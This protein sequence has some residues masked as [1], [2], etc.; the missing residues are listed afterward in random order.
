[1]F[2]FPQDLSWTILRN[3]SL[4]GNIHQGSPSERKKE[5]EN[6][7]KAWQEAK[8]MVRGILTLFR[9]GGGQKDP[10]TSFSLV[11][12]TNVRISP[13]NFLTFSFNHFDRLV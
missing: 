7:Q 1:M 9:M 3:D 11:T 4:Y 6:G 13:Q 2:M 5:K 10:P 12:S 8:G